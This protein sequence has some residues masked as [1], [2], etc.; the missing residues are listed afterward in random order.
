MFHTV[1][2]RVNRAV[3]T[4]VLQFKLSFWHSDWT[5]ARSVVWNG[6][7]CIGLGLITKRPSP[8]SHLAA[9]SCEAT[10]GLLLLTKIVPVAFISSVQASSV[11]A[12]SMKLSAS[13]DPSI[14][15]PHACSHGSLGATLHGSANSNAD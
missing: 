5:E 8:H 4:Y 15:Y 1:C 12:E 14:A 10:D 7:R 13:F 9:L 6:T 2:V 3:Y 11:Q